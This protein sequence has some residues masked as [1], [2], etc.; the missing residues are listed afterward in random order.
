MIPRVGL[1]FLLAYGVGGT[2]LAQTHSRIQI[3][4]VESQQLSLMQSMGIPLDCGAHLH[5]SDEHVSAHQDMILELSGLEMR[6]LEQAGIE[7]TVLIEQLETYYAEQ[8]HTDLPAALKNLEWQKTHAA[9]QIRNVG[10]ELGCY[11]ELFEVPQYFELGSMGGF[12]TYE[13]LLATLDS[14]HM[15][16]PELITARM[17]I[18]DSL[19]T[20][21][22]RPVYMV[23]ISDNAEVDE[24]EAEVL[25]TGVHHAREPAS[26]MN[27]L[28]FMWYLLENYE[29]DQEVR[30]LVDHRELYFIPLVN[31]DGYLKNQRDHPSGGG[32]WRK[33]RRVN[34]DGS[35]GV[36]LN[37]NYGFKWGL[38]NT[39]SSPS[40]VS[41]TF[42]GRGPFSEPE[43][44]MVKEFVER[45]NFRTAFHNH[46]YSNLLLS[47]WSY[48]DSVNQEAPIFSS[49]SNHMTWFNR[50]RF[51]QASQVLYRVNG[52]ATDWFYG[53]QTAKDKIYTFVPEIGSAREGGFWPSPI[54]IVP[55][56]QRQMRMSLLLAYFAGNYG[57]LHDLT[58]M[59]LD[60]IR[61]E[62][63]FSV[64]RLGL[65]NGP[66]T[67][68]VRPLS[69]NLHLMTQQMKIRELEVLDQQTIRFPYQLDS[70]S[71]PGETIDYEITL[72][73]DSFDLYTETVSKTFR[74]QQILDQETMPAIDM[75]WGG[76]WGP[77]RDAF[78]GETSWTDSPSGSYG[79]GEF[80]LELLRPLDFGRYSEVFAEYYTKWELD[81]QSDWFHFAASVDGT[82]FF[83]YCGRYTRV[84]AGLPYDMKV[85]GSQKDWVQERHDLTHL[86]GEREVW[87]RLNLKATAT[88]H[89]D[90]VYVNNL[91]LYGQYDCS[92]HEVSLS[93]TI[94]PPTR[95]GIPDGEIDIQ[96]EGGLSDFRFRWSTG[97]TTEDVSQLVAGEYVLQYVDASGCQ[98]QSVFQLD[99][100]WVDE[101]ASMHVFPNPATE[102]VELYV[103]HLSS[104]VNWTVS[105]SSILGQQLYH[106]EVVLQDGILFHRISVGELPAGLYLL[107]LRGEQSQWVKKIVVR[108]K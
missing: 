65:G 5:T 79:E 4:E 43:T 64:E 9:T 31:P 108:S 52:G 8:A 75:R 94:S 19:R 42:R 33:N 56:C 39:G 84:R 45:H 97:D 67:V 88:D 35:I 40:S 30:G 103:D 1:L 28:F 83:P 92:Q 26:A 14:M 49:W 57:L 91:R 48:V 13:E 89:A 22:G 72:S 105:L 7:Y 37:R 73:N 18:S 87:L 27:L 70:G 60:G 24:E 41:N 106:K 58:P 90:G 69:P 93:S 68:S 12:P 107:Q 21:E 98:G 76:S 34:Q 53:E 85:F 20:I 15:R 59:S 66:L 95:P 17:A 74:M 50:Y 36:D 6:Q 102:F 32:M 23:K 2:I 86:G 3:H 55:Q 61:G 11:E 51:G 71:W 25:Y 46:A 10:Q 63:V 80:R 44:R 82:T 81:Q 96:L 47:P 78:S 99:A 77:S 101:A 54:H 16:F 104:E 38:D 100:R 62:L 29:T